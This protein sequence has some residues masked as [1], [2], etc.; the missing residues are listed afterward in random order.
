MEFFLGGGCLAAQE[1]P[2]LYINLNKIYTYLYVNHN[3]QIIN[4][5]NDKT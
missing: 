1:L 4:E 2:S 3:L 5:I